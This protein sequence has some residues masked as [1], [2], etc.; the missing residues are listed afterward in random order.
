VVGS[1][2][3]N[4]R[5]MLSHAHPELQHAQYV[6]FADSSRRY[7]DC[8]EDVCA[9]LGY[10]RAE[11][12]QKTIDDVSFSSSE[13][14]TLFVQ[15]LETGRQDGEYVLR[16]KDGAPVLIRYQSF[17]FSDGC[18]AAIWEPIRDWREPYL[19]ALL[20]LDATKLKRKIEIAMVAIQQARQANNP[21]AQAG[22]TEQAIV[23]ALSALNSLR[24]NIR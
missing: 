13:V 2:I 9:L 24:R 18:K 7:L 17:V 19:A 10:S 21:A 1:G 3:P 5:L 22:K 16:R 20:E 4:L 23:D 11:M 8:S 6:V 14:S 15:Y 12:L